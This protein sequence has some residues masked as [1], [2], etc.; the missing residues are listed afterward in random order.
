MTGQPDGDNPIM[1]RLAA[2]FRARCLEDA[3]FLRRWHRGEAPDGE[4]RSRLHK[5]AGAGGSFG[6][7]QVSEKA[8]AL[9]EV[10]ACGG[11][12]DPATIDILLDLLTSIGAETPAGE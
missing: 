11:E 12:P 4:A 8:A 10:L 3:A 5:L 6:F 7:A 2:R 9:E 1:A